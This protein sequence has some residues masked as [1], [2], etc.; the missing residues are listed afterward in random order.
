MEQHFLDT[1]AMGLR[2]RS[3]RTTFGLSRDSFVKEIGSFS[4]SSVRKWESGD[5]VPSLGAVVAICN[6]FNVSVDEL[7]LGFSSRETH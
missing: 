1:K 3:L 7:V 2:I 4:V 6:R 5:S